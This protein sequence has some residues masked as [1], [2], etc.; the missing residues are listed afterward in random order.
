MNNKIITMLETAFTPECTFEQVHKSVNEVKKMY[1]QN[2]YETSTKILGEVTLTIPNLLESLCNIFSYKRDI[3][4]G[5]F[6]AVDI[7]KELIRLC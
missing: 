1:Q 7:I 6:L 5:D 3:T 2:C 4:D